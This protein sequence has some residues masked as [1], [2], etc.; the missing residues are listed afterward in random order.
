MVCCCESDDGNLPAE[1]AFLRDEMMW[2][3]DD[4]SVRRHREQNF[5]L[6]IEKFG[7]AAQSFEGHR[8]HSVT[9][10]NLYDSNTIIDLPY[11]M[12]SRYVNTFRPHGIRKV[13]HPLK[14]RDGKKLSLQTICLCNLDPDISH[15]GRHILEADP[16]SEW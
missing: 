4:V 2:F 9:S 12:D 11:K 1:S 14:L 3:A 13:P 6:M 8:L 7:E 15:V 5:E 16:R 10:L